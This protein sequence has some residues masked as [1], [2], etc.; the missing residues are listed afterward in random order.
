MS[1]DGAD[2]TLVIANRGAAQIATIHGIP[3]G[4][5]WRSV[6]GD[7]FRHVDADLG[8]LPLPAASI[9]T[10]TTRRGHRV[11]GTAERS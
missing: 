9:T 6:E 8:S 3:G 7:L 11:P 1:P 2:L 5:V 10:V 4:D